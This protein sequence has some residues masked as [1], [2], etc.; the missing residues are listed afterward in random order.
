M[1]PTSAIL[2]EL[3]KGAVM[4][5]RYALYEELDKLNDFLNAIE[6]DGDYEPSYNVAPSQIVPVAVGSKD[7]NRY[8]GPMN[9][10]FIPFPP[11]K[12]HR[13]FRVI[14]TRDDSIMKKPFWKK[15]LQER[16]CI[17]PING[18]YEWKG[19]KGNKTPYYIHAR[20]GVFLG[21]AG[22]WSEIRTEGDDHATF[23]IITTSPN[24]LME[25][26]HDRMPAI[27]HPSEFEWWLDRDHDDPAELLEL[28]RP[29]PSEAM[30]AYIVSKAVGNVRNDNP[31]LVQPAS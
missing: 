18:F 19:P 29:Y 17:V 5:G 24:E 16:R 6:R 21:L 31:E 27:L 10:G 23:S 3:Y 28:L 30:E 13:P 25:D 7:G 1:F 22:L 2:T 9:W 26:I 11:K 8:L 12:D 20:E 14:N 4:C 15:A